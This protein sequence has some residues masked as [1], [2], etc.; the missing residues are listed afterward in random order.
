[1]LLC[2]TRRVGNTRTVLIVRDRAHP[3]PDGLP[4]SMGVVCVGGYTVGETMNR[5]AVLALFMGHRLNELVGFEV[6]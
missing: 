2:E 3:F 4:M 6:A 5:F 1:M